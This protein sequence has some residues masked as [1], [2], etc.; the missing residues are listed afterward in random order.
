MQYAKS[1]ILNIPTL[2]Y[3]I[4]I[5]GFTNNNSTGTQAARSMV[6]VADVLFTKV[7]Q[8]VLGLLFG[9]P[10]RSFYANEIINL[11]QSGT[12]AVQRELGRLQASGL[13]TVEKIGRQKHYRANRS[14]PVFEELRG[15][16]LKTVGL[17]DVIGEAMEP[18]KEQIS[19]AFVYGSV[20]KG[21]DTTGSDIDLMVISDSLT[22]ADIFGALEPASE[23]L[24]RPVNPTV[25][26]GEE[27]LKRVRGENSFLTRVLAG[28][29]IWIIG[30]DN[31]I[32]AG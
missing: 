30:S 8:R 26:S 7:Q 12:G 27:L 10:D 11:A 1:T 14:S 18:L 25:Y 9:S 28:D 5:M 6:G 20:A 29:K 16:I 22:Y 4:P 32:E 3:I 31:E 13:V 19:A 2:G 17:A 24:G 15:L 23:R 21:S